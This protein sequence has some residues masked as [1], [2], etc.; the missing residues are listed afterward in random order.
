MYQIIK[1]TS[2]DVSL[3]QMQTFPDDHNNLTKIQKHKLQ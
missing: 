1:I 3:K 2:S